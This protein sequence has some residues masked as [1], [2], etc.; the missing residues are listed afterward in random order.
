M[1]PSHF[2]S[3][4][5]RTLE[6]SLDSHSHGWLLALVLS[7]ATVA[8][9]RG[10]VFLVW[11]ASG[12][13]FEFHVASWLDV[14]GQWKEGIVFPRWTEWANHGFGEPRFIFYPPLSW[15]LGAAL[16]FRRPVD[17]RSGCVHRVGA[18]L[19]G[20]FGVCVRT[21]SFAGARGTLRRGVLRGQS[22]CAADYLHAQRLRGACWRPRFF[23]CC[24]WL[25]ALRA[26]RRVLESR[27]RI[28]GP[29]D[30][31][32]FLWRLPRFG[33]RTHLPA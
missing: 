24:F 7:F 22:E 23:R 30:G 25:R 28:Y 10:A 31:V 26:R 21:A 3:S 11:S 12:H 14:A 4:A 6:S 5:T 13:D 33:C 8:A 1:T 20:S 27:S 18:D 15:L 17:L 16:S 32:F 19:R 2:A 9:D 29:C